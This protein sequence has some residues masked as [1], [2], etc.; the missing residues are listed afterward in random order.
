MF[1]LTFLEECFRNKEG[2]RDKAFY[3]FDILY[4]F[5]VYLYFKTTESI[6]LMHY[7]I[8]LNLNLVHL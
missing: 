8:K 1:L 7:F 2:F 6:E 5:K 3:F 4:I